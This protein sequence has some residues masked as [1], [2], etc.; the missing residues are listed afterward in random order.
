MKI[1]V[2]EILDD[3]LFDE[4]EESA[5]IHMEFYRRNGERQIKELYWDESAHKE[6]DTKTIEDVFSDIINQ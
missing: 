3:Y 5:Y 2:N 6:V 1:R 4:Q